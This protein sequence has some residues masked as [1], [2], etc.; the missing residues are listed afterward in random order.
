[1]FLLNNRMRLVLTQ[2]YIGRFIALISNLKHLT[3]DILFRCSPEGLYIQEFDDSRICII[4]VNLNKKWFNV[5]KCEDEEEIGINAETLSVILTKCFNKD[6]LRLSFETN[7]AEPDKLIVSMEGSKTNTKRFC[8]PCMEINSE[9]FEI[10]PMEFSVDVKMNLKYIVKMFNELSYFDDEVNIKCLDETIKLLSDGDMG[11]MEIDIMGKD[12][13]ENV[14]EFGIDED[15]DNSYDTTY[16]LRFLNIVG[17]FHKLS[18][19][20]NIHLLNDFPINIVYSL[21]YV[22]GNV[23]KNDKEIRQFNEPIK[24]T[25]DIENYV[26]FYIAP[27]MDD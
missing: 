1:M 8:L 17:S 11:K 26:K 23:K 24:D 4:E 19:V 9:S 6:F 14:I 18:K 27:K 10:P 21:D 20:V 5:F 16:S 13:S 15:Y 22:I 12:S 7:D 2:E 25:C 3:Q